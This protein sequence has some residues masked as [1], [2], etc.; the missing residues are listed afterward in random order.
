MVKVFA[1]ATVAN[2]CSGFDILGLCLSNI[3]D[4]ITVEKINEKKVIIDSNFDLPKDP[5]KNT[6][7]AGLVSLIKNKNLN[8]GFKIFIEKNIPIGSGLGG[9]A[10]SAVGAILGANQFL[11]NKM[12][13]KEML[14]YALKGE[15]ATGSSHLDNITPCL[16]GGFTMALDGQQKKLPYYKK[17]KVLILHQDVK[18]ITADSRNILAGDVPIKTQIKQSQALVSL[19][20][21]MEYK[22]IFGENNKLIKDGLQDFIVEPLRKNNIPN[23][24]LIKNTLSKKSLGGGISGSGPSMFFLYLPE[25]EAQLK[26]EVSKLKKLNL[27]IFWEEINDKGAYIL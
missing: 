23:F 24:D 13:S 3:G 1:P 19:I 26:K 12:G 6:A 4:T 9:S 25:Q 17:L 10:S 27:N 11:E 20:K 16:L 2:L 7:G 5:N 14:E 21:G 8:Y 22:G 18:I 15:A